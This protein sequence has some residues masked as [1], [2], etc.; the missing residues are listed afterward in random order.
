MGLHKEVLYKAKKDVH[1]SRLQNG[2]Y[3]TTVQENK[4]FPILMICSLNIIHVA[5]D[6]KHV[7]QHKHGTNLSYILVKYMLLTLNIYNQE[8]TKNLFQ[9][10]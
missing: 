9:H 8:H 4:I 1:R 5:I 7:N 2:K 3:A 6:Q 10:S